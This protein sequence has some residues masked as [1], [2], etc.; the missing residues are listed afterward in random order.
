MHPTNAPQ[1]LN[2]PG[3]GPAG[4]CPLQPDWALE[5]LQLWPAGKLRFHP[6]T[7]GLCPWVGL[8]LGR[9]GWEDFRVSARMTGPFSLTA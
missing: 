3:P 6:S 2:L 1:S 8:C 7:G 9:N 4:L 5:P